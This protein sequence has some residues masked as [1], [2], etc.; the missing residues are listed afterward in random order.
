MTARN[1]IESA[2]FESAVFYRGT[3]PGDTRRIREPFGAAKGLTFMARSRDSAAQYGTSVEAIRTKPSAVILREEDPAF[4][5]LIGRRRPP[6]GYVGSALRKGESLVDLVN[7][8]INRA[9]EAGYA[10]IS[11][12]SDADIGTVMLK[13]DEFERDSADA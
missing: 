7:L 2:V 8:A 5:R 13:P 10:A 12:A 3:T 6:N 9:R 11:F 4:W 1:L